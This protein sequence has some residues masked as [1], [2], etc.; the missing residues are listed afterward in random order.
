M[1]AL[2]IPSLACQLTIWSPSQNSI[3]H[4]GLFLKPALMKK[5][6]ASS[7]SSFLLPTHLL[8]H[9]STN[10]LF[11]WAHS[12]GYLLCADIG[13]SPKMASILISSISEFI[14]NNQVRNN[15]KIMWLLSLKPWVPI[16]LYRFLLWL[17]TLASFLF[18]CFILYSFLFFCSLN[19]C[20]FGVQ[21]AGSLGNMMVKNINKKDS[22]KAY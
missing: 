18:I 4:L 15:T 16:D 1:T 11:I 12:S 20:S 17:G 3:P 5:T 9:S 6:K 22:G 2:F 7:G 19:F 21:K 8:F 13:S 14:K 10:S